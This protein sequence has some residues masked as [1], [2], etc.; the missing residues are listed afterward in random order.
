MAALAG[1]AL[2]GYRL[3][4]GEDRR[5]RARLSDGD[6]QCRRGARQRGAQLLDGDVEADAAL[7]EPACFPSSTSRPIAYAF[8]SSLC[9]SASNSART[10]RR[11]A[12]QK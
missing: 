3:R 12:R 2:S 7:L 8:A 10:L 6:R 9:Q 1:S 5:T 4:L 11:V